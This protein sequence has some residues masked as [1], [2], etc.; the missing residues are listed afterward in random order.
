LQI[1]RFEKIEDSII[2][3]FAG[4]PKY[5]ISQNIEDSTITSFSGFPKYSKFQ[6]FFKNPDF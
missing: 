6:I 1:L 4:F 2:S 5:K 3:R